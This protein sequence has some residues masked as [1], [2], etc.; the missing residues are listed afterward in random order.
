[1]IV[2]DTQERWRGPFEDGSADDGKIADAIE[3]CAMLARAASVLKMRTISAKQD[4]E[5]YGETMA[6]IAAELPQDATVVERTTFSAMTN[7]VV[8]A[9]E[10][11][12]E[13][14]EGLN[15]VVVCGMEIH[16]AVLQTALDLLRNGTNVFV[17]IDCVASRPGREAD[18]D[19]AI[20][21]LEAAGAVITTAETLLLQLVPDTKS[22][23]FGEVGQMLELEG[24]GDDAA[25]DDDE[26]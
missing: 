21:M 7:E 3:S 19:A 8:D 5:Y 11:A 12:A 6:E 24:E 14:D 17:P 26:Q 13:S 18:F 22:E 9:V 16:G 25:D 1:L 4:S 10:E 15:G 2:C 23:F 20:Q